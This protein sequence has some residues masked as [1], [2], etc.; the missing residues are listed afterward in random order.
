[1]MGSVER[2]PITETKARIAELADRGARE[3]DHFT[4]TRTCL[5]PATAMSGRDI[6]T[7][8]STG[9]SAGGARA[10]TPPVG[11]CGLARFSPGL[12]RDWQYPS[13][14]DQSWGAISDCYALN[15]TDTDVWACYYTD[16]P[17]VRIRDGAVTSWPSTVAGTRALAMYDDRVALYGG[18]GPDQDRLATGQLTANGVQVTGKY[19]VVLPGGQPIPAR[20]QVIGRWCLNRSAC[21]L[22]AR[23][24]GKSGSF[25]VTHGQTGHA[26]DLRKQ[27]SAPMHPIPSK[28]VMR[29]RLPSPAL[30]CPGWSRTFFGV[31]SHDVRGI[32]SRGVP[33]TCHTVTWIMR[34]AH[35]V[36]ALRLT[37]PWCRWCRAR[38]GRT[39]REP[40]QS[41]GR[42]RGWRAGRSSPPGRW[43]DRDRS[44]RSAPGT[45]CSTAT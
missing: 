41:P 27:R 37:L 40:W 28:L 16:W 14:A 4:I 3:H 30:T 12:Q 11:A 13:H 23:S 29:F 38:R 25:T 20:T 6:S 32:V 17:V 9:T 36:P 8:A 26:A 31:R 2:I 45:V 44:R 42:G 5:P 22:R 21:P 39:F 15:V 19:R 24:D 34:L 43:S 18:Y 33:H 7:R 1:M 35:R 10:A